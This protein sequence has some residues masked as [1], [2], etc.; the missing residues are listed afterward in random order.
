MKSEI[1]KKLKVQSLLSVLI[2]VIGIV[3]LT[4]MII[5]ESEPGAIPL[6][7][8]ALGTGCY[9]ITRFRIRSQYAP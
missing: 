1:H 7:L 2:T 6:L 4:F 9:F 5:V 3:L 8:I